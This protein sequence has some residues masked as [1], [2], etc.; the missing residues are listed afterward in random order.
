MLSKIRGHVMNVP[1]VKEGGA[2]VDDREWHADGTESDAPCAIPVGLVPGSSSLCV[3]VLTIKFKLSR[4]ADLFMQQVRG[5]R[6]L[7]MENTY[8]TNECAGS[9]KASLQTCTI[10]SLPSPLLASNSSSSDFLGMPL[11]SK[12]DFTS[13]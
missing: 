12:S 13:Q 3:K 11:A 4:L 10:L 7:W 5:R 1:C 8:S 9:G 6:S 2:D